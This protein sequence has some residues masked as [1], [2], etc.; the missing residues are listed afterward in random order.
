VSVSTLL[1]KASSPRP[2]FSSAMRLEEDS[3]STCQTRG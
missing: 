2:R 3:S 1:R